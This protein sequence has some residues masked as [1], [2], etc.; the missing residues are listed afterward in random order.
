MD[1]NVAY[2]HSVS[3]DLKRI[4]KSEAKAILDQIEKEL[5]KNPDAYP[6]LKGRFKGLRK[7]RIGDY[8]VIYA[9]L[10]SDVLILRIGLRKEVYKK[11]P[12][13]N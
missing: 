1:Y 5:S 10:D 8:R 6:V 4:S 11:H 9:I 12:S 3:R 7:F 13:I 2:K